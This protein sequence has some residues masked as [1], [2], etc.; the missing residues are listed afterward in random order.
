MAFQQMGANVTI[1]EK[2]DD[3][4]KVNLQDAG[5]TAT[6]WIALVKCP[7]ASALVMALVT[8]DAAGTALYNK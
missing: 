4:I 7:Q 6:G 8:D 3:F 2:H 1:L 5:S